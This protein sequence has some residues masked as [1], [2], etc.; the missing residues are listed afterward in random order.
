VRAEV[1]W[2]ADPAAAVRDYQG[3]APLQVGEAF[4]PT[5]ENCDARDHRIKLA[6]GLEASL[7]NKKTRGGQVDFLLTLRLGDAAVRHNEHLAPTVV[8]GFMDYATQKHDPVQLADEIKRLKMVLRINSSASLCSLGFSTDR[9]HLGEAL[10]LAVEMLR[11][12]RFDPQYLEIWRQRALRTAQEVRGEPQ[13]LAA[14]ALSRHYNP[15]PQDDSRYVPT[16]E[17]GEQAARELKI[18]QVQS[19]YRRA[20]G[21]STGQI[22]VVGDFDAGEVERELNQLLSDWKSPQTYQRSPDKSLEAPPM[23]LTIPLKDKASAYVFA[24]ENILVNDRDPDAPA[25]LLANYILGGGFLSSRLATR[26]RQK[27]GLSYGISST[28]TLPSFEPTGFF[29]VTASCAPQNAAQVE[30]DIRD[31]LG[32][33]LKDGFSA[34]EV[35][36]AKEGILKGLLGARGSDANLAITLVHQQYLGRRFTWTREREDALRALTPEAVLT[37]MRKY[38]SVEKLSFVRSG[39]L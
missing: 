16:V 38:L 23:N 27:E 36:R 26:I 25:L 2:V 31:E 22:A 35:A 37:A 34:D 12:P 5:P 39:S 33:A 32:R 15:Y 14:L 10:K 9:A 20:Y 19:F 7:F 1:P 30:A 29:R 24:G 3:A 4:T 8:A 11:Q 13:A 17:E 6:G 28:L 21:A 18:D